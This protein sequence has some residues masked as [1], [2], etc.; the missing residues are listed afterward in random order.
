P[1]FSGQAIGNW[2][3]G[4]A[5]SGLAGEDFLVLGTATTVY[6]AIGL[7]GVPIVFAYIGDLTPGATITY[8]TYITVFGVMRL[9][10]DDDYVVG[11]DPNVMVMYAWVG[12]GQIRIEIQSDNALDNGAAIPYE[13]SLKT[14]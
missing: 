5:T 2:Q 12:R 8:R 3:S 7:F 4:T 13:Y 9:A 6:F 1:F 11:V 14:Y 10:E